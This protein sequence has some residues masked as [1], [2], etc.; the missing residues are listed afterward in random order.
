MT[1][2]VLRASLLSCRIMESHHSFTLHPILFINGF[3]NEMTANLVR[4]CSTCM[5]VTVYVP[6]LSSGFENDCHIGVHKTTQFI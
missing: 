2:Q 6:I 4:I 5:P 1:G 3:I